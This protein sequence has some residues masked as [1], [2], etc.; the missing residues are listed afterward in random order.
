MDS[1]GNLY[2]ADTDHGCIKKFDLEGHLLFQWKTLFWLER[3]YYGKKPVGI[4]VDAYD[5]LYVVDR[6][7]GTVSLFDTFGNSINHWLPAESNRLNEPEGIAVADDGTIYVADKGNDRIQLFDAEGNSIAI[8]RGD[9]GHSFTHPHDVAI[10]A[11]G[12]I[13]VADTGNH[14]IQKLDAQGHWQKNIGQFGHSEDSTIPEFNSPWRIKIDTQGNIYVADTNNHR[15]QKLDAEG[16]RLS[17]LSSGAGEE[18]GQFN[19]PKG[20]AIDSWQNVYVVDSASNR[21]QEWIAVSEF[22]AVIQKAVGTLLKAL[23]KLASQRNQ[24]NDINGCLTQLSL[25]TEEF[26][27][28]IQFHNLL[29]SETDVSEEEWDAIYTSLVHV[30]MRRQYAAWRA[31][32]TDLCLSPDYFQIADTDPENLPQSLNFRRARRDWQ[33]TLKTRIAQEKTVTA[34][35]ADVVDSCEE[36]TLPILRDALVEAAG[37]GEDLYSKAKYLSDRLLIDCQTGS[38][39]KTTRVS[40]ALTTL[41]KLVFSLRTG[42]L[43]DT[44]NLSLTDTENL[45]IEWQ[46]IGSYETFKAAVGV[47][48]YPET[49]LLP[50]LRRRKTPAFK[51]LIRALRNNRRLTPEGARS[52]AENYAEYFNDVCQLDLKATCQAETQID[53]DTSRS[54][55]Y[56]FAQGGVT[57]K[58]YWSAYDSSSEEPGYA[59]TF[60]EVIPGLENIKVSDVVGAIPYKPANKDARFIYLF[61]ETESGKYKE[62]RFTKFNLQQQLNWDSA[63][64]DPL[65]IPKDSKTFKAV[66]KQSNSNE[67]QPP[68]IAFRLTNGAIYDREIN[69]SGSDWAE[70]EGDWLPIVNAKRGVEFKKIEAMIQPVGLGDKNYCLVARRFQEIPNTGGLFYRIFGSYDDGL[71]RP[72]EEE[73]YEILCRG[74][75]LCSANNRWYILIKN[76]STNEVFSRFLWFPSVYRIDEQDLLGA[77]NTEELESLNNLLWNIFGLSLTDIPQEYEGENDI[78]YIYPYSR[79]ENYYEFLMTDDESVSYIDKYNSVEYFEKT[80]IAKNDGWNYASHFSAKYIGWK[81]PFIQDFSEYYPREFIPILIC[82]LFVGGSSGGCLQRKH[83]LDNCRMN[84]YGEIS[85]PA[86]EGFS[87][88]PS[89]FQGPN[90]EILMAYKTSRGLLSRIYNIDQRDILV[91]LKDVKSSIEIDSPISIEDM[92]LLGSLQDYRDLIRQIFEENISEIQEE[93][94]GV[95]IEIPSSNLAYLE[96]V[97]YFVSVSIALQLQY[98]GEYTAALGWF[99]TVYDYTSEPDKKKIYY[100]LELE[101]HGSEISLDYNWLLNPLDVHR[102]ASIRTN[103]YTAFTISAI[104]RCLLAYGDAEFTRDTAESLP[105]ARTLYDS[106]L[107]LIPELLSLSTISDQ[108]RSHQPNENQPTTLSLHPSLSERHSSA[109]Q[110]S[111]R[112]LSNASLEE[113]VV[114]LATRVEQAS[115]ATHTFRTLD[116]TVEFLEIIGGFITP[117]NPIFQILGFHPANNLEKI[118][119]CRNIA[120]VKRQVEAYAGPTDLLSAVPSIGAGGQLVLPTRITAPPVPYRYEFLIERSK[121]LANIASQMEAAFLSALEKTDAERYSL[122]KARQDAQLARAGVRLQT[123]RIRQAEDEVGLAE[124]QQESAEIQFQYYEDWLN[125][126]LNASE[127]WVIG[128]LY[129]AAGAYTL[130]AIMHTWS[131]DWK[132][133]QKA[134]A[135]SASATGEAL[136]AWAQVAQIYAAQE[137]RE[138][139]WKLQRD[140]AQQSIR[141]GDQQIKIA[142]DGVKIVEQERKISEIQVEH[143]Q[144]ILEFLNTKETNAELYDWMN[145]ILE[146]IYSYFLQQ[147]TAMAKLAQSQLAFERQEPPPAFIQADYWE[148]PSENPM[149]GTT[150]DTIDRHGLTGSARLLADIYK[151]DQYRLETEK[152]KL[153][154]TKTISLART[155]PFE[156]QQFKET[157]VLPFATPMTMFD[158]DFPGH[159]L[160]LIKRVRTSVIALIPP[161]EG[162]KATLTHIGVSRVVVNSNGIFQPRYVNRAPESVALTSPQN[163]TGLFE[164]E[165][166]SEMLL[167]FESLGVD[168]QWEFRLPKPANPFDYT[169]IADILITLEYT[170]LDSYDYRKQVIQELDKTLSGDRPFSFKNQFADAWYDL[171]NPAPDTPM[172]VHFR[173]RREDFPPNL[174]NLEIEHVLLYFARLDGETAEISTSLKFK[175]DS[176][177]GDFGGDGE[178]LD[179]LISTRRGTGSWT[180]MIGASPIGEWTLAF[181]DVNVMKQKFQDEAIEDILLVITYKG[182]TP[183]WPT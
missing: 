114:Q 166:Q 61:L 117:P 183:E 170:A 157:G 146:G 5:T 161:T 82:Q 119:T 19:Q 29:L 96:E 14:Q 2:V 163:A 17:I 85:F 159:Y 171:H 145:T 151:L 126:G 80:Y 93:N 50:S 79:F 120:G 9:P 15:I 78:I 122:L 30:Q 8:W 130:A 143:A 59:Q 90:Q 128:L 118:R 154:L 134:L 98:S 110:T 141:I 67:E 153:Q 46:W 97:F 3:Q 131:A 11:D 104:I 45:D 160:R 32:E 20:I 175:P 180:L 95:I 23:D 155:A 179:G 106:S 33:G 142:N 109:L 64:S 101:Q 172:T 136:S 165:T 41:Q 137:Y 73:Y 53:A 86:L 18:I 71:W 24:G 133:W 152:R 177:D 102:I 158:R 37:T 43:D 68:H 42:Q 124:L 148:V 100:G 57:G 10:G 49:V 77:S 16:N 181:T 1:Q 149:G 87:I 81:I 125:E 127:K 92:A 6:E 31:E 44:L 7:G 144:D 28:L 173:T 52:L 22:E 105:N 65:E 174:S 167:P 4:A 162:I 150:E 48:L 75:F 47:L 99:R 103:A 35:M 63:L 182:D 70:L 55:F 94:G 116:L 139:E 40:Q 62:L 26:L 74:Y 169:T 112:L 66:L 34:A 91:T 111:Q 27:S 69:N 140:L 56:M 38:C 178:T 21:V 25:T 60:W 108:F 138:N 88:S 115:R 72:V 84:I 83:R 13:Y 54:L 132:S 39:Q 156:F 76:L 135:E 107:D 51:D 121:Q 147:A 113:T 168:G 176:G 123:L 58:V 89:Y 129:A 12:Y 164:L 36:A